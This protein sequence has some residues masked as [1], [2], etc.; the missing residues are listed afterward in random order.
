MSLS[1]YEQYLYHCR[2]WM[3]EY[4]LSFA[5]IE[6]MPLELLLGLEVVGSKV[7]AAFEEKKRTKKNGLNKHYNGEKVFI[8][9]I[10]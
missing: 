6:S 7:E 5:E 10:L 3:S 2:R 4:H 8:D 9:Q 1:L